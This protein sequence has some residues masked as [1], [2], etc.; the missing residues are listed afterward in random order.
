MNDEEYL[1]INECFA[2]DS[3]KYRSERERYSEGE[4]VFWKNFSDWGKNS[5][6]KDFCGIYRGIPKED[7]K[8]DDIY[9]LRDPDYYSERLYKFHER[10]WNNQSQK[11]NNNKELK[12][13]IPKVIKKKE[14]YVYQLDTENKQL[15]LGS[16]S[17]IS[18]YWH[19]ENMQKIVRDVSSNIT[20]TS[21]YIQFK[22]ETEQLDDCTKTIRCYN[23]DWQQNNPFKLFIWR[24]LQKS[25]TIGGFIVFPRHNKSTIN[26]AR[27]AKFYDRFDL[28]L[29]CIR[30]YYLNPE[31]LT[32]EYNPLFCTLSYNTEFFDKEKE[33]FEMFG[34]F[35]NYVDFFC[36][37]DWIDVNNEYRVYDL[38]GDTVT[39]LLDA[40]KV[41]KENKVLP[42]DFETDDETKVKKWWNL[43]HNL[44]YRL[45]KRNKRIEEILNSKK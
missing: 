15:C 41:W 34:S 35:K 6:R 27:N 4:C 12:L 16:D 11:F 38:L 43:Y 40:D 32:E 10:L 44:M 25:N 42:C 30:R 9:C 23:E 14:G 5:N 45:E 1:D 8:V 17:F 20:K 3:I 18:I 37:Q 19:R 29:E 31:N 39:T 22:K 21:E 28:A 36:L 7:G 13:N 24:Y 33:F 26:T 2:D